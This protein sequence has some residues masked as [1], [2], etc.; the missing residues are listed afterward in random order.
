MASQ[1]NA[2]KKRKEQEKQ[3]KREEKK[4]QRVC[5]EEE[6]EEALVQV[7]IEEAP[8]AQVT[9]PSADLPASSS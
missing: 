8:A 7:K 6:P 4:K 2:A 9:D 1:R 3:R 5:K